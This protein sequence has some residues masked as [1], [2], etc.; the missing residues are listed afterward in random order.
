MHRFTIDKYHPNF[1]DGNFDHG[2]CGHVDVFDP[3][4]GRKVAEQALADAA[5]VDRA[6]AAARQTHIRGDLADL[7]PRERG[8]FVCKI[9]EFLRDHIEE[10]KQMVTIEQGKP[11]FEADVEVNGAIRLFEYFG[12]LA[13]SLEG[14]SIPTDSTRL[15]FTAYKPYGVSAQ[16]V[17]GHY[18]IYIPARSIAVALATGNACVVKSSTMA[19][20]SLIWF[21]RAA[22][23][24]GLPRGALNILCGSGEDAGQTLAA[25]QDINHLVFSGHVKTAA[26]VLPRSAANLI[27]SV[28]EV[29]GTNPTIAFEDASLDVLISEARTG[30]Y[31][32]AGQFCTA[33][34]RIIIHES[35]YDEFVERAVALAQS[36]QPRPGIE[37]ESFGPF[38]GPLDSEANLEHVLALV[39][40]ACAQ[41]A[42]CL[43]GG[44]RADCPGSFMQPTVLVDV[45][46][47]ARIAQEEIW[48]PVMVVLK[49]RDEAEAFQIA[50]DVRYTGIICGVFTNKLGR[51]TR[52]AQKVNAGHLVANASV[53]SG[54]EVPF[55]GGFGTSGYGRVKGREAM[56]GY[57]QTKNLLMPVGEFLPEIEQQSRVVNEQSAS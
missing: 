37:C 41:G 13:E 51:L 32:N 31:W 50:N 39:Q 2:G 48:G 54:A 34:Y 35:L 19:P 10:I 49:F 33:M 28:V 56:L 18:P 24:C 6:V 23:E 53:I 22:E 57:V 7:H 16:F 8:A 12:G 47:T 3:S 29:G 30:T 11:L 17:P 25:H 36:L 44:K 52:A 20:L 9:G 43:A 45:D 42:R 4:N 27:P 21:A 38:M 46:P 40:E 1:I 26:K 55:G 5:D 14:R 15:D